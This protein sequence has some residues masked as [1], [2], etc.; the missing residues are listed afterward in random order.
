MTATMCVQGRRGQGERIKGQKLIT[1]ICLLKLHV[2][3]GAFTCSYSY[4]IQNN[5][6]NDVLSSLKPTGHCKRLTGLRIQHRLFCFH[7]VCFYQFHT[8][9]PAVLSI[10]PIYQ[11]TLESMLNTRTIC[12][13]LL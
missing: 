7:I 3:L 4:N 2:E 10:D 9:L 13:S 6:R 11:N 8:K 1:F 5:L 12:V